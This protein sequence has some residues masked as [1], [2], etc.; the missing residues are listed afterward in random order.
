MIHHKS[1]YREW[2]KPRSLAIA[3]VAGMLVI[4]TACA[5]GPDYVRPKDEAPAAYKEA[6]E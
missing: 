4:F 5:V 2:A 3:A 6:A 1:G